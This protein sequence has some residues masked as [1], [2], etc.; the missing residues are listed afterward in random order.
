MEHFELQE[1]VDDALA[2]GKLRPEM[3][4][5]YVYEFEH[6]GK[7]VR[8]L[9]AASYSHIGLLKGLSTEKI[10]RIEKEE[11]V[12]YEVVVVQ[13]ESDL[14]SE[15]WIRKTGVAYQPYIVN[16]KFDN[17]CFQKAMT[18]AVRN[19]IKQH[20]TATERHEAINKLQGIGV[21]QPDPVRVPGEAE[22]AALDKYRSKRDQLNVTEQVFWENV[23]ERYEVKSREDMTEEQWTDFIEWID[24]ATQHGLQPVEGPERG[25]F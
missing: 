10:E 1:L 25:D 23:K 13:I 21:S 5:A 22:V 7:W 20:I 17:F 3:I 15:Q 6:R 19:A 18:K 4:N 2:I 8:D 12:L 9:S 14:P 11:G 24:D 16:G